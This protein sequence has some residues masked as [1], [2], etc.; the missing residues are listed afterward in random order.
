LADDVRNWQRQLAAAM[1]RELNH[2]N[3]LAARRAA[4]RARRR[5]E[6]LPIKRTTIRC[7]RAL[8]ATDPFPQ[9][10]GRQKRQ[11]RT[12]TPTPRSRGRSLT[13]CRYGRQILLP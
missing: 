8:G 2:A 1:T 5:S 9:V 7:R 3:A 6:K 4:A 12:R 11:T 10:P 13:I